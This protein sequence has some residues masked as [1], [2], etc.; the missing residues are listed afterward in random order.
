ML[1]HPQKTVRPLVSQAGYE[2]EQDLSF[3]HKCVGEVLLCLLFPQKLLLQR[4]DRI[5]QG[6]TVI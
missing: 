4:R 1:G 5:F 2:P 6:Y 3:P